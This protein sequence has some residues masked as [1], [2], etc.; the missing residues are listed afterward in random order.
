MWSSITQTS[1][2]LK[3]FFPVTW[4]ALGMLPKTLQGS[5]AAYLWT[6]PWKP[7]LQ[8]LT[9]DW[10]IA[11]IGAAAATAHRVALTL[12]SSFPRAAFVQ[13][14][15]LVFYPNPIQ[16]WRQ[17]PLMVNL[18]YV[19]IVILNRNNGNVP[20]KIYMWSGLWEEPYVLELHEVKSRLSCGLLCITV[21]SLIAFPLTIHRSS[22]YCIFSPS[23]DVSVSSLDLKN[24]TW[25]FQTW[26]S[27]Q[28]SKVKWSFW[29]L[30][31]E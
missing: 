22:R 21:L 25:N 3:A 29:N 27:Y 6:A 15:I 17:R 10:L 9:V 23:I 20:M 28:Y 18:W 14:N 4:I 24:L 2:K 30:A 8:I 31:A 19:T 11:M 7:V 1:V 13:G 12:D 26:S 5:S 16:G